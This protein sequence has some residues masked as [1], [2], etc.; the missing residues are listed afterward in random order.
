MGGTDLDGMNFDAVGNGFGDEVGQIVFALGIVAGKAVQ[1]SFEFGVG[2][3][4]NAGIDFFHGF[5]GGIGVFFFDNGGYAAVAV[6]DDAAQTCRVVGHVGQQANFVACG[7]E[8]GFEGG[9]VNQGDVAVQHQRAAFGRQVRQGGFNG[10]AGTELFGLFNPND[11]AFDG[12]QDLLFAVA[13]D[14]AD[15]LGIQG[16]GGVDNAL[17]HGKAADAVQHF[18]HFGV[19]ARAFAGGEDDDI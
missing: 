19:H 15:V 4:Q 9:C 1:P 2:Q 17:N 16:G 7:F 3:N 13:D 12:V 5:L 8:Q 10:V 14:D 18:G 11:I 6:A